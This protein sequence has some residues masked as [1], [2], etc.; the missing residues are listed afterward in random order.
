MIKIIDRFKKLFFCKHTNITYFSSTI[1]DFSPH[2]LCFFR[3]D[4]CGCTIAKMKSFDEAPLYDPDAILRFT[5][6]KELNHDKNNK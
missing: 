4:L 5:K 3:C 2:V 1:I 6:G